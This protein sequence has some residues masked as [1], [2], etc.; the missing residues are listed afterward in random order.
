MSN[1]GLT[2]C[3]LYLDGFVPPTIITGIDSNQIL[4]QYR[5]PD[6]NGFITSYETTGCG[7]CLNP[8]PSP[9]ATMTPTPTPYPIYYWYWSSSINPQSGYFGTFGTISNTSS[10][11]ISRI[12]IDPITSNGIN[13]TSFLST[14]VNGDTLEIQ[15]GTKARQFYI[16]QVS[17]PTGGNY[18]F[19][20][21]P[22]GVCTTQKKFDFTNT[23]Y[24]IKF[25]KR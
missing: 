7:L 16:T 15:S 20:L 9:T 19:D 25:F 17:T 13:L 5:Y 8:T 23:L 14:L 22:Q 4:K 10:C 11:F 21:A 1:L 18:V 6:N 12:F 3:C 24:N 2:D